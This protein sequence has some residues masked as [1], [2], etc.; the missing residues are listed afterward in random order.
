MFMF[1]CIG[2]LAG[3]MAGGPIGLGAGF[4]AGILGDIV[5]FGSILKR[6]NPGS[7]STLACC[8]ILHIFKS[9]QSRKIDWME[10]SRNE[11]GKRKKLI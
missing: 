9:R 3:F 4:A 5:I 2:A 6:N 7:N 10:K 8:N 11:V 1:C